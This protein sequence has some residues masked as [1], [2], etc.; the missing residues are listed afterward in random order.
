MA[1]DADTLKDYIET[2]WSL[3][4]QLS[5]TAATGINEY[6][7]FYAHPQV[8]A[9]ESRK[10]IEVRQVTPTENITIHPKFEEVRV[11]YLIRCRYTVEG[12]APDV[13]DNAES[14]MQA[15][16]DEINRILDTLYNPITFTGTFFSSSRNWQNMDEIGETTHV[17]IRELTLSLTK[18]RSGLTSAFIGYG[19]VLVFKNTESQG[20]NKPGNDYTYTEAYD[21]QVEEGFAQIKENITGNPDGKGVPAF[22]RGTYSG[23][24][25]CNMYAK[26]ADVGVQTNQLNTIFKQLSNGSIATIAF[27]QKVPT[28]RTSPQGYLNDLIYFKPTR[29]IRIYNQEQMVG[30]R[31]QG[32]MTKPATMT[33]T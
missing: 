27:L 24:F 25:Q 14:N 11:D 30:F 28:I 4:G 20:D 29:F 17:L 5:K 2:N 9:T 1:Y 19:G 21:V 10:A 23:F 33:V 6:V 3:T 16:T 31:L 15:M 18:I 12:I 26:E 32:E 22:Y 7:W 13:Y 8:D